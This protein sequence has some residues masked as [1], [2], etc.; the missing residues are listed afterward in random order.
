MCGALFLISHPLQVV[1]AETSEA[2]RAQEPGPTGP[3]HAPQHPLSVGSA[4]QETV[5]MQFSSRTWHFQRMG[6]LLLDSGIPDPQGLRLLMDGV[7]AS[8]GS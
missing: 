5:L 7:L 6:L 8:P 2:T 3:G 4:S 1:S